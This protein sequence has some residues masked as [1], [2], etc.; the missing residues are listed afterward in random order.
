[1]KFRKADGITALN[2]DL[3]SKKALLRRCGVEVPNTQ[4]RATRDAAIA[5][6]K[7]QK[8]AAKAKALGDGESKKSKKKK[9]GKR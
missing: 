8:D 6:R 1:M 2:K 4:V 3:A 9:K 7:A 5:E